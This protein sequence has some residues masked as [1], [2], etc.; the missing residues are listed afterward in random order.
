MIYLLDWYELEE[1]YGG[2]SGTYFSFNNID[3]VQLPR[4][5][6]SSLTVYP[7]HNLTPRT[8]SYIQGSLDGTYWDPFQAFNFLHKAKRDTDAKHKWIN[9]TIAAEIAIKEFLIRNKPEL[10]TFILEVPSPPLHKL[11]GTV[12]ESLFGQR[13][14]KLKELNEGAFKR[15]KII[16]SPQETNISTEEVEQYIRDVEHA[17]FQLISINYGQDSLIESYLS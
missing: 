10:T 16:H 2:S 3:W 12:L 14:S 4:Q 13:S 8:E 17:I 11:Y 15:N 5:I 1:G 6:S 7:K 9:A